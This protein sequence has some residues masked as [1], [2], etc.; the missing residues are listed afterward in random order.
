MAW[1]FSIGHTEYDVDG[2][3]PQHKSFDVGQLRVW[4]KVNG[5]WKVAARFSRP[6]DVPFVPY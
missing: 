5:L 6:L 1:E 3:P 2:T 4:R